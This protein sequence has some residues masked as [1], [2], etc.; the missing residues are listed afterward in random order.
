MDSEIKNLSTQLAENGIPHRVDGRTIH[1]NLFAQNIDTQRSRKK[2][3]VTIN[4]IEYAIPHGI[5]LKVLAI[6]DINNSQKKQTT[7]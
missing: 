6:D 2:D 5:T 3:F 7:K 1:I 4:G